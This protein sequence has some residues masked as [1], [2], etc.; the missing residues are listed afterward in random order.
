MADIFVT[1]KLAVEPAEV[2]G[3]A[4]SVAIFGEPRPPARD[5]LHAGT[6]GARALVALLS[7]VVDDELLDMAPRLE[8]VANHAVGY[9][10]V[11]VGACTRRGV[12]VTNTPDVLTAATADLTW[13]L[14]LATVRRLREGER[15]VRT[16]AFRHW[17]PTLL[18]GMELEGRTLGIFG[19]GRIG[20]A[21]AR[22]AAGFG[23]RVIHT[24]RRSGVP[25]DEL[26]SESDVISIHAPLTAATRHAF[27]RRAFAR[28]RPGAVLVNTAR[29]PIV[30]EGALVRALEEGR[31]GGAGLDVYENEPS[32]HPGLVD[33][34]DVV[35]L[36]HVGS[37]TEAARRRMG[38]MALSNVVAVLSGR[39]P[40]NAVNEPR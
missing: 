26:L 2:I 38:A 31:L 34:D 5:E 30:D 40:P 29:G 13:A 4:W 19:R 37:A 21:V 33:R 36:P 7:D 6:A 32:V 11:D 17:S 15:M 12:W 3:D 20:E 23:M 8:I 10:N 28:M 25:F 27:D 18:L 24:S 1:R 39:R 14:L 22:R 16:A 35:L 9:D